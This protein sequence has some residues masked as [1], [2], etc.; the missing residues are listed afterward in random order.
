M[1]S[2]PTFR[3]TKTS[4]KTRWQSP[5]KQFARLPCPNI[6][7]FR[8][9]SPA[10]F[11]HGGW[12]GNTNVAFFSL[13]AYSSW[14]FWLGNSDFRVQMEQSIPVYP[15][16]PGQCLR[17]ISS[18]SWHILLTP[19]ISFQIC[20]QSSRLAADPAIKWPASVTL[21]DWILSDILYFLTLTLTL[22]PIQVME[23]IC[24][25]TN[26]KSPDH[27]CTF[28]FPFSLSILIVV[29]VFF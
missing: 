25:K 18:Q 10:T 29:Y 23:E 11:K 4:R 13:L 12:G 17:E 5:Q 8:T 6:N 27:C 1:T 21:M 2:E 20:S 24:L 7:E 3:K 19:I 22:T 26:C 14:N 15:V 28:W 16:L 9:S